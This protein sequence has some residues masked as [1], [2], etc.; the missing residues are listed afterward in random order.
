[1][2]APVKVLAENQDIRKMLDRLSHDA[3][4]PVSAH[5]LRSTANARDPGV[6]HAHLD[7]LLR[8][9]PGIFL[10]RYRM[11]IS[12]QELQVFKAIDDSAVQHYVRQCTDVTQSAPKVGVSK[13]VK[14]RRFAMMKKLV[15]L[16]P[17]TPC[18]GHVS[19]CKC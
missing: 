18:S 13:A 9:E 7:S 12:A 11:V 15:R 8:R 17:R 16:V 5:F 6:L 1:M 3:E 4:L 2:A 14:N 10:E 19:Q